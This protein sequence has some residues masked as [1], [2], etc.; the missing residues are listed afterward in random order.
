MDLTP[1]TGKGVVIALVL[2]FIIG[3]AVFATGLYVWLALSVVFI[4]AG[5][6]VYTAAVGLHTRATDWFAGR[7]S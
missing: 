4:L 5:W 1:S 2:A 6:L 3:A 7:R